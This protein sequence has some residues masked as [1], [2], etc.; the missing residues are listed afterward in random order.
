VF[1]LLAA[2]KRTQPNNRITPHQGLWKSL[3]AQG[4]VLPKGEFMP[5]SIIVEEDGLRALS[6]LKFDLSQLESIHSVMLRTQGAIFF[7]AESDSLTKVSR[8]IKEGWPVANTKPPEEIAAVICDNSGLVI[9]LYG[10]FD[11]LEVAVAAIGKER[12]IANLEE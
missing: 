12:V 11:D 1:W 5:E 10:E 8:L 9:D 2:H 7:G 6:A 3:Q 4:V